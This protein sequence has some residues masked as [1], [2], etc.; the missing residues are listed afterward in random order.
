MVDAAKSEVWFTPA[1]QAD[2]PETDQISYRLKVPSHLEKIQFKKMIRSLGGRLWGPEELR[3]AMRVAIGRLFD[4]ES[5]QAERDEWLAFLNGYWQLADEFAGF[6]QKHRQFI[7]S[8]GTSGI[9][10]GSQSDDIKGV[11]SAIQGLAEKFDYISG[12]LYRGD[13]TYRDMLADN[14]AYFPISN[15]VALSMFIL[16][17]KGI[18]AKCDRNRDGLKESS[19]PHIPENHLLELDLKLGSL[20]SPSEKQE[21][22]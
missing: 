16:E 1:D 3:A 7:L 17:W 4:E 11:I 14:A 5:E 21:K 20:M 22:N 8:E 2:Q 13:Q 9:D 10:P 6:D 18:E 12:C 15:Y 19:F